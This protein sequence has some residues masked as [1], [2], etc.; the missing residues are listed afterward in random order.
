MLAGRKP[1]MFPSAKMTPHDAYYC[2][3]AA[4]S[5]FIATTDLIR[6]WGGSLLHTVSVTARDAELPRRYQK[7]LCI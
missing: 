6:Q 2:H 5:D 7:Q 3:F 1:K 4:I